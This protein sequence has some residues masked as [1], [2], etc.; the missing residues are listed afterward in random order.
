LFI[1]STSLIRFKKSVLTPSIL[2]ERLPGFS[3]QKTTPEKYYRGDG[4][5][6]I[7]VTAVFAT[8]IMHLSNNATE[9]D[10]AKY[11]QDKKCS[12]CP[13]PQKPLE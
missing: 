4:L 1:F 9:R 10:I 3:R 2:P 8:T 5:V 13:V 6:L 7:I 12:E 11:K